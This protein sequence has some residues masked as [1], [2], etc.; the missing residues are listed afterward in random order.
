[1]AP[2]APAAES[3][4][5]A[6]E[7]G[8]P[9]ALV[10]IPAGSSGTHAQ[11][12]FGADSAVPA[13]DGSGPAGWDIKG[14]AD[15]MLFHTPQSPWYRRTKAEVWFRSEEAALAAG[16]TNALDRRRGAKEES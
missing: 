10:D 3:A 5:V 13:A 15:S 2:S 8:A 1:M 7:S 6:T 16:F 9:A 11:G 12:R 14:N 4:P